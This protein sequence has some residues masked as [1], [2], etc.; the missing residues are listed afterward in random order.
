VVL[1]A[2]TAP[3]MWLAPGCGART[4]VDEETDGDEQ[5]AGSDAADGGEDA[6]ADAPVDA[7][8]DV[9]ADVEPD[10]LEDA[11]PDSPPDSPADAPPDSPED[12]PPDA[13][14]DAPPDS[15]P[16]SPADAPP[17]GACPDN[18]GD[19]YTACDGDCDDGNPLINPGA[20]DFPNGIDDDC[21]GG[22]D[23][24]ILN[25]S[26]GLQYT[27]QDPLDYA[28]A[29]DIC[30]TTTADAMGADLKWGLISAELRLADG[31]GTPAPTSHAI[32]TAMGNVLGPRM[33]S[34]FVLFSSGHAAAPGHPYYQGGTPQ[35]GTGFGI[36]SA[37]PPGFPTNKA[38]CPI[39]FG[40]IAFD[41]VNL[42]LSIRTP[43]NAK[44]L[45][46][47]H[48]FF[49][50]EYPEYA[51]SGFNDLWVT[52]LQTGA[53]GIANNKNIIFDT[54]GTPGSVNL[55]FFDRCVAGPTGCAG[56]PGFNFCSGGKA[57]L[58]GTGYGDPDAPCGVQ[59][60]IGGAT[61]WVTTE[62]PVLPGEVITVQFMVWDSSDGIFDS[63]AIFDN[64]RWLQGS[65][66]N[67]KTY[68]P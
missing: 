35:G 13:P 15:P 48:A 37:A 17:D 64:F 34:N 38:G 2:L 26:A 59:S 57:E 18:D 21:D 51:C 36:S 14:A 39:P 3:A 44:S 50:S 41:P 25:C 63:A 8:E 46:F 11:P 10:S 19:G 29:I 30:Q 49:S 33:N 67:P 31:T 56:M 6:S 68:R 47:D 32:I 4:D 60:S 20:F 12:A 9:T 40:S 66:P 42:K 27:S 62:A 58:S 43:T 24:P 1:A 7:P 52:L 65:L 22:I 28:K 54:Q 16:D 53:A 55:N 5:D 45:G 61:G 23:N